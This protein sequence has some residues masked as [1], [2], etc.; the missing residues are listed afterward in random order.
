MQF[1][2]WYCFRCSGSNCCAQFHISCGIFAGYNYQ[3]QQKRKHIALMYC[4]NHSYI[5]DQ[6]KIVHINQKV[7]AR[8]LQHKR[9]SECRIIKIDK[10]P[11]G[12]VKFSDNT[13]S[14]S[15]TLN[16]IKNY[17]DNFPPIDKMIHLKSGDKGL[18]LALN[19][20]HIYTV[21]YKDGTSGCLFPDDICS[22][23]EQFNSSL[24]RHAK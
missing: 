7:W 1:N 5:P 3:I 8:H 17:A 21:E 19:Y 14:D 11:L 18:F 12:I 10:T 20:K 22:L 15:I 6:N 24:Q 9:I 16:E 4:N 23:D 13:I 2:I